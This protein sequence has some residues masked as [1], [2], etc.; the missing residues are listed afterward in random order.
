M[1][2]IARSLIAL[3]DNLLTI[4]LLTE[5]SPRKLIKTYE[6]LNQQRTYSKLSK[7][8]DS[9]KCPKFLESIYNNDTSWGKTTAKQQRTKK[10]KANKY[11]HI[12]H[13][14]VK[15]ND[16]LHLDK[17]NGNDIVNSDK[18]QN[19]DKTFPFVPIFGNAVT[20]KEQDIPEPKEQHNDTT[21]HEIMSVDVV[22]TNQRYENPDQA[23]TVPS[24]KTIQVVEIERL[25]RQTIQIKK[26]VSILPAN[27]S[28]TMSL[29][30]EEIF[31]QDVEMTDLDRTNVFNTLNSKVPIDN[32]TLQS[33]AVVDLGRYCLGCKRKLALES[34][35]AE[36]PNAKRP[37]IEQAVQAYSRLETPNH[38]EKTSSGSPIS[39]IVS[40]NTANPKNG[41]PIS[42]IVSKNKAPNPK[43]ATPIST[44]VSKN[45]APNPENNLVPVAINTSS[46]Y[47][48]KNRRKRK[49]HKRKNSLNVNLNVEITTANRRKLSFQQTLFIQEQLICIILE[50][51]NNDSEY[52]TDIFIPKFIR[53][54]VYAKGILKLWCE[55]TCTLI[56][57]KHSINLLPIPDLV[58]KRQCDKSIRIQFIKAGIFIP[59]IYYEK[60]KI[61]QVLKF[62]NPWAAIETWPIN[63]VKKR[64]DYM[65]FSFGIPFEIMARILDRNCVMQFVMG[66]VRVRFFEGKKLIEIPHD[67][68]TGPRARMFQPRWRQQCFPV[69]NLAFILPR[70]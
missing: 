70:H 63:S 21:R 41:S 47:S 49:S 38:I 60:D 11:I 13:E 18:I 42:T 66:T 68:I 58:V 8:N 54:P 19:R 12:V 27:S 32:N 46:D 55:D 35:S 1:S 43:N 57:L 52:S 29:D 4:P 50:C 14:T 15:A 22:D 2:L 7:N 24:K 36:M 62:M 48:S 53:K 45:R 26:S 3:Q 23:K 37:R 5:I 51:A 17:A 40:K 34:D 9:E 64:G 16:Q 56:W 67:I 59:W 61:I 10:R 6:N 28:N 20:N 31:L 69:P 25:Q 30:L 39:T 33:N 65:L 44:I